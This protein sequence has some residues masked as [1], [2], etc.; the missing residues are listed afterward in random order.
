[1][2]YLDFASKVDTPLGA[3]WHAQ[4]NDVQSVVEFCADAGIRAT[5]RAQH[6]FDSAARA[7]GERGTGWHGMNGAFDYTALCALVRDGWPEGAQKMQALQIDVPRARSIRRR[8]QWTD[9]GDSICMQRVYTGQLDRAWQRA[10]R[11]SAVGTVNK[12]IVADVCANA[13][14]RGHELMWRGAAVLKLSDL[15][16]T[17]GYNVEIIAADCARGAYERTA[18]HSIITVKVKDARDPLEINSLAA[19][20]ACPAFF[21]GFLFQV[22][23]A[24]SQRK[25]S[26]SL[27]SHGTPESFGIVPDGAIGG[28]SKVRDADT[29]RAWIIASLKTLGVETE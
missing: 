16:Q 21:R 13:D 29:A 17:A 14:V 2:R 23:C 9:A 7:I 26:D 3:A 19:V 28:V 22:N 24:N 27:G 18:E 25:A 4:F 20:V 5:A 1:M 8:L 15:L 12:T 11:Q 6:R 10:T